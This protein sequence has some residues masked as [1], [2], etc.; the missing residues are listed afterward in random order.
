MMLE[1]ISKKSGA[2]DKQF[3]PGGTI[4]EKECIL[5]G[6]CLQVCPIFSLTAKE[7]LSP[8]AKY[9]LLQ[10]LGAAKKELSENKVK[11]LTDICLNCE[12]CVSICPQ[13]LN[14]PCSI[15]GLKSRSPGWKARIWG[16]LLNN[17]HLFY[18]LLSGWKKS[19]HLWADSRGTTVGDKREIFPWL[20]ISAVKSLGKG[21]QAVLFPGCLARFGVVRW[22]DTAQELIKRANY[23]LLDMPDWNCCGFAIFRAGLPEETQK[24]QQGNLDLWRELNK[25]YIFV[26]CT[27]CLKA[28]REMAQ[29]DLD[30]QGEEEEWLA[31]LVPVSWILQECE[32][33]LRA[34]YTDMELLLHRPCHACDR[35][36]NNWKLIFQ[37]TN[38]KEIDQCCGFGGCLQ[39]E[40]PGIPKLLGRHYWEGCAITDRPRQLLTECSACILQLNRFKPANTQVLHCLDV[41]RF[42]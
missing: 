39:I 41:I 38:I 25:P 37:G 26:L 12:R 24:L 42:P 17:L 22:K 19:K 1:E 6:K 13:G 4:P 7:E 15:L 10:E 36:W 14:I 21:A 8:R 11:K 9:F 33:E 27:S 23:S 34:R 3:D 31:C 32:P 35:D 28:L 2:G 20:Q 18:P 16:K 30:W 5:C 29:N 40:N